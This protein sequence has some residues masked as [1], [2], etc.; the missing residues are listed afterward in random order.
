MLRIYLNQEQN[1][2]R[3]VKATQMVCTVDHIERYRSHRRGERDL[4]TNVG[5]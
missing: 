5:V 3:P 4:L 2:E 1:S